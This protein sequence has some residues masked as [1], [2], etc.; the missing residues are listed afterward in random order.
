MYIVVNQE[1]RFY[2]GNWIKLKETYP[3]LWTPYPKQAK[4]YQKQGWAQQ[5]AHRWGGQVQALDPHARPG[6]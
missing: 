4:R 3:F 6:Q 5:V 1:G 2:T